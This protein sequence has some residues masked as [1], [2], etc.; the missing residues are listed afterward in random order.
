MPTLLEP[1]GLVAELLACREW[2]WRLQTRRDYVEEGPVL[3]H[4]LADGKVRL[5][6]WPWWEAWLDLVSSLD[7]KVART[8]VYDEPETDWQ[9][10]QRSTQRWHTDAGE[11]WDAMTRGIAEAGGVPL[12]DFW[13][14]DGEALIFMLYDEAG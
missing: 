7:G 11:G 13:L 5:A 1:R 4:F 2:A 12:Y 6:D 10:L 14:I 8:V 9:R 3:E